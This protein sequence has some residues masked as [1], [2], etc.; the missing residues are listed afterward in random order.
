M[1]SFGANATPPT[2]CS[3]GSRRGESPPLWL[4][5]PLPCLASPDKIAA[6]PGGRCCWGQRA[7]GAEPDELA[8]MKRA[9]PGGGRPEHNTLEV[10]PLGAGQEVGRSCCHVT[11]KGK[12]VMVRGRRAN[13]RPLALTLLR[14]SCLSSTLTF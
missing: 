1:E 7:W 10:M 8:G 13:P 9:G 2:G 11:Y 6:G 12:T 5:C 3:G 4:L 14:L